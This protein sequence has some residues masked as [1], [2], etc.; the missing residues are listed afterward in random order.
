MIKNSFIFIIFGFI[1][2]SII[3]N[4]QDSL[5][6]R[7]TIAKLSS[8]EFCGRGYAYKGDSIAAAFIA[9]EFKNL[10]LHKW[11]PDYYQSFTINMNVFE[12]DAL[13]Y[14]G[15]K[16]SKVQLFENTQIMAYS[17][18]M[19]GSFTVKEVKAKDIFNNKV[20]LSDN[21]NK[22]FILIDISRLNTKDSISK[23][24]YN[25]VLETVTKNPLHAKGYILVSEKLLGW[26]VA[27]G[28]IK[29][30]HVTVNVTK[31][32]LKKKP[33]QIFL[34]LHS[35]HI[36]NYQTQ[37]VCGYIK[38]TEYPDSF[39]VFIAHYDHL[40]QFGKD[41]IFYGANDNASGTAFIMDL[42]RHFSKAENQPKYSIA[43]LAVSCEEIGLEGSK[44]YVSN[45]LFPL[46]Q[47]KTA[48]NFD[49][50]GTGENG[51]TVVCGQVF[52]DE[53]NK[54]KSL[55]DEHHFLK[56]VK[57]R[58]CSNNSDH[59]PFYSKGVQAFFIYGMG[60]SGRYHHKSDTLENMSLGGY[61]G[62]FQLITNYINL[63]NAK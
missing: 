15:E 16:Y 17:C 23:Q 1:L 41:Y 43:F 49:M 51:I 9:D 32:Y 56:E 48:I 19:H 34:N 38:G 58:E 44:Y 53:Y 52:P 20:N 40:G 10:G 21:K 50:V 24:I 6:F 22:G 59:Y 62:L 25:K 33:K 14:F 37:N 30:E 35:R 29:A 60:K 11:T 5:Y 54:L 8:A 55:N 63:Y 7:Q 27:Y 26:P 45:S 12:G 31:E 2:T 39:F 47:I 4:A 57:D 42:A 28:R 36:E 18:P 3:A 13:V 61:T 46:S